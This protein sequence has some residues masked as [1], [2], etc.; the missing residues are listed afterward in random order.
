MTVSGK[1]IG[2]I[3]ADD[4]RTSTVFEKYG[5]DFCC[6][7]QVLLSE[8][9]KEKGINPETITA[10]LDT[11][12]SKHIERDQNY[13]S[14]ELP[15]LIDYI[16]NVHHGYL[17]ENTEHIKAH[18]QKIA[19]VHGERHSELLEI[20]TIFDKIANDMSTHLKEEE[21]VFFPALK[22][23]VLNKKT[24]SVLSA[25]DVELISHSLENLVQDH[26]EIGE[27]VHKINHL[28]NGYIIP[29]DACNTFNLTYRELKEFE[30]DL[31]KHVHLENNILFKKASK[32][33]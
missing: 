16:V 17:N 20:S 33:V 5:I 4:Y 14:W 15:F 8:A 19:A 11:L 24:N 25:E 32:L 7:G 21:D 10:E 29:D 28:S 31:H 6:G 27:A 30:D 13:G 22:R 12:K 1:T 23:A 9:C 2:E 26:E 3:V 18:T